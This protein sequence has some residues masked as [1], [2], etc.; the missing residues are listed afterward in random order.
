VIF[1]ID[2]QLP[3]A[4]ATWLIE[5]GHPPNMSTILV[6]ATLMTSRSGTT[7]QRV[8][9]SSLQ[10]MKISLNAPLARQLVQ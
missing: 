5:Q 2:A 7:P 1:L 9:Q 6:C 4:L 8:A 10:K 3:P